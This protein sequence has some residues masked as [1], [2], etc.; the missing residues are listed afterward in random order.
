MGRVD[1]QEEFVVH[2]SKERVEHHTSLRA[3]LWKRSDAKLQGLRHIV[4]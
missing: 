3:K 4:P 2:M 1:S